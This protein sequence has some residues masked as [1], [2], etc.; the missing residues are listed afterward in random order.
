MTT[1]EMI[2]VM[3][4]YERGE[5]I[6]MHSRCAFNKDD[7]KDID[8]PLW[9]WGDIE[10]RIKSKPAYRPYKNADEFL[11]AQKE[12]GMWLSSKQVASYFMPVRLT[13][14]I[15]EICAINSDGLFEARGMCFQELIEKYVWQDGTPC[16]VKE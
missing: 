10:Y 15:I 3:Q 7:W 9:N 2:E 6:E 8:S 11:A 12:H 14:Q 1:E 5:V 16:G 4:A 13:G